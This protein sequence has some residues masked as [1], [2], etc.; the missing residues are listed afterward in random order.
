M[1]ARTLSLALVASCC[2]SLQMLLVQVQG[3]KVE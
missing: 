2:A 1:L 3:T